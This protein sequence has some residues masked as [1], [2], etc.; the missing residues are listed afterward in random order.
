V[1]ESVLDIAVGVIGGEG[2]PFL[3]EVRP[4]DRH[5]GGMLAFPGGKCRSGE[6]PEEALR[7]EI[8]EEVGLEPTNITPLITIPWQ[9]PERRLRLHV[10]RITDWT[11]EPHGRE[12]QT[13]RWSTL[14]ELWAQPFPPA[15][16]GIL[17]ALQL[18]R[19]MIV[20]A[21]CAPGNRGFATW[22]AELAATVD[23]LSSRDALVQLR[24][25][26]ELDA[27]QWRQAVS[28]VSAVGLSALINRQG[29]ADAPAVEGA[30]GRHL[31][32]TALMQLDS[33]E[34]LRRGWVTAAVHDARQLERAN[35]LAVDAIVVS[36][37][38]PTRSHPDAEPLGWA[39]FAELAARAQMP[40]YALG[41]LTSADLARVVDAGGHGIAAISAFWR[42][43]A[44]SNNAEESHS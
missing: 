22:L 35:R 21:A 38:R 12:G 4:D 39:G 5:L 29:A 2:G 25:G 44:L 33:P 8:R 7:R 24:P 10:Y 23:V 30:Q 11:G 32:S 34:A 17:S 31:S 42:K 9:Y 1:S 15:N 16:R 27:M 6:R 19:T 13:L 14:S 3:I 41:G 20:S 28:V 37:V 36:P 18:P 26:R 40:V 43:G